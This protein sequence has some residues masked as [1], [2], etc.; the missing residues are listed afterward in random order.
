MFHAKGKTGPGCHAEID[1]TITPE[2]CHV[3]QGLAELM[4]LAEGACETSGKLYE[5]RQVLSDLPKD[6]PRKNGP[7]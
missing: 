4:N 3:P 5:W 6:I 2:S 7:F 1:G